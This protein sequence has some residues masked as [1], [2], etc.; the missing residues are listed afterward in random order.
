MVVF[1]KVVVFNKK[2]L[3]SGTL[4]LFG[5]NVVFLPK[6]VVFG[7]NWLYSGKSSCIRVR[8]L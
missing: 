5:Q 6:L 1:C 7:Q 4:V 8:L 3:Y 2:S